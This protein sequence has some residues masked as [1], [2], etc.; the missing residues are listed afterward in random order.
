MN[1]DSKWKESF[2]DTSGIFLGLLVGIAFEKGIGS[3][4]LLLFEVEIIVAAVVIG[5]AVWLKRAEISSFK[6]YRRLVL[7]GA[8]WVVGVLAGFLFATGYALIV[9]VWWLGIPLSTLYFVFIVSI[10]RYSKIV[11][12]SGAHEKPSEKLGISRK[13]ARMQLEQL[14]ID[15]NNVLEQFD[16]LNKQLASGTGQASQLKLQISELQSKYDRIVMN[17]N[18]TRDWYSIYVFE[19]LESESRILKWLTIVLIALTV[20]LTIFTGFLVS[21]IRF[22]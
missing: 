10:L 13:D 7:R 17:L 12:G 6:T 11:E 19:S 8:R 21:G 3:V 5:I 15:S 14:I 18:L 1:L 4:F 9:L 16:E 22:P 2:V 20:V